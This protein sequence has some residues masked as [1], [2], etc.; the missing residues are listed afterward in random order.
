MTLN[1]FSP[2]WTSRR[3][4]HILT[5][6][7]P[8]VGVQSA[9]TLG[10][11]LINSGVLAGATLQSCAV[12]INPAE[13]ISLFTFSTW[14]VSASRLWQLSKVKWCVNPV[15][16]NILILY[17]PCFW[18]LLHISCSGLF[19][20]KKLFVISVSMPK[21]LL[22]GARNVEIRVTNKHRCLFHFLRSISKF[23]FDD[24]ILT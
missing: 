16:W 23:S 24:L 9:P 3:S 21:N 8:K 10:G 1:S 4:V 6:N 14:P 22:C 5:K 12:R 17:D 18:S 7:L 15:I 11:F 2:S 20:I 13:L 19:W